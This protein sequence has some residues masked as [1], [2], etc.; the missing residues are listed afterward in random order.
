MGVLPK[1]LFEFVIDRDAG[2][3][4][5]AEKDQIDRGTFVVAEL[6]ALEFF[7]DDGFD[8]E[9][10]AE[11]ARKSLF[12]GFTWINFAAGEFPLESVPVVA[13][14]LTDEDFSGMSD[15]A[16]HDGNWFCHCSP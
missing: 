3:V 1:D 13:L 16:R 6:V 11:F 2:E 12:G 14:A 10:L 5:D 7:A 15:D 4:S 8:A 9:F